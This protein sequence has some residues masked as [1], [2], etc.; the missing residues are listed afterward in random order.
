M[1]RKSSSS[2]TLLI[3]GAVGVGLLVLATRGQAQGGGASNTSGTAVEKGNYWEGD[4]GRLYVGYGS[5]E[6]GLN[7]LKATNPEGFADVKKRIQRLRRSM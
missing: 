5:G 3:V 7:N 1:A 6:E 4:S 2:T